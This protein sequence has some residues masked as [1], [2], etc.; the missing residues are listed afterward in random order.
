MIS[1]A[2]NQGCSERLMINI[3]NLMHEIN[4]LT[5]SY[6]M[7]HEVEKEV[8]SEVA[9]KG[10]ALTEVTMAIKYARNS[11]PGRYN[12]PG[13]TEVA[14]IFREPL[15]ERDLLIHCKPDPNNPSA[16]KMKQISI[17]FPTLDSMTLRL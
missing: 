11:D 1:N 2:E 5:K 3:N 4:G 12:S 8:Q 9:V 10:I 16:T 13:L 6:K 14:V 15:F 7:L 17:L